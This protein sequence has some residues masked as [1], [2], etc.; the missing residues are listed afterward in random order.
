MVRQEVAA[1]IAP[2]RAELQSLRAVFEGS[3]GPA[4]DTPVVSATEDVPA[5][6]AP[7]AQPPVS[8]PTPVPA[9][10]DDFARMLRRGLEAEAR[11][12]AEDADSP[13]A[14]RKGWNPFRR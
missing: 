3:S 2:L 6:A 5:Q 7:V 11:Q 12:S 9:E 10:R 1:A 13:P 8:S 4:R 14:P